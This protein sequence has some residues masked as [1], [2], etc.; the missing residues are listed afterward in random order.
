MNETYYEKE[1]DL[2]WLVYRVLRGWRKIVIWA[3]VIAVALGC[4]SAISGLLR[5]NDEEF[6]EEAYATYER[7][8]DGWL[9][10]KENLLAQLDNLDKAK[11]RQLDYNEKSV[12]MMIDPLRKNVASF[13]LY[14]KY[15]Y[16]IMPDMVYQNIDMSDRILK[17]YV[18]YMTNGEMYEYI[19][20]DLSYDI[21]LR[22]LKEI[23]SIS[24]DYGNN[25]ISVTVTHKSAEECQEILA[26]VREGIAEQGKSV[27]A[28]I[29]EHEVIVTNQAAYETIDLGLEDTQDANKRYLTELDISIQEVNEELSEWAEEP[30]PEFS[31]STTEIVKS[32]IKMFI[33]GGVG[34]AVVVAVVIACVALLSDK[35]LNPADMK[36]RFGLRVIGQLPQNQ[37]NQPF[38]FVSRWFAAFAGISVK[39]EEYETLAKMIGA[40]VKSDVSS[41]REL[42]CKTIAFTGTAPVEEMEKAVAAMGIKDYAVVCAPN[43]LTDAASVEKVAEADCVILIEKQERTAMADVAKELE[44]LKAWGKTVLGVVVLNVDAVM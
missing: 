35:L 2:K 12:M 6:L 42:I 44:A 33:L 36:D 24:S 13:E 3:V 17:T 19:I 14:V 5:V 8:H 4:Y 20:D 40:S 34:G 25:M 16:E 39:P 18:T 23:L 22:Y 28:S 43:M 21:E 9:A 37:V 1:I 32:A 29:A 38:A 10:K 7:D 30:E 26:L 41:R 15:D 27:K 31:Y 11:T